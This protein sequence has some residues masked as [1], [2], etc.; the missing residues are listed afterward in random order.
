MSILSI[1][2]VINLLLLAAV[3]VLHKGLKHIQSG[4][5]IN[6]ARFYD[7]LKSI[8][9]DPSYPVHIVRL[10]S[11]IEAHMADKNFTRSLVLAELS[12]YV[13]PYPMLTTAK[14]LKGRIESLPECKRDEFAVVFYSGVMAASFRS[15]FWGPIYRRILFSARYLPNAANAPLKVSSNHSL[16]TITNALAVSRSP[17]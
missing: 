13:R 6:Q 10:L 11:Y 9:R 12:G 14:V 2:I 8:S 15:F 5:S 16:M 7:G 17:G 1:G 4:A 3:L